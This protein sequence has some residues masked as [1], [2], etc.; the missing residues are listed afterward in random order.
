[1]SKFGVIIAKAAPV[2]KKVAPVVCAAA[3]S[4]WQALSEQKAALHV[5]DL[6]KRIK[7]LE[8]LFKK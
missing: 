6:E 1:M 3:F 8:G 7:D 4:A 2:A 5:E